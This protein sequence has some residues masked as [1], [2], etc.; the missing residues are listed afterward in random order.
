MLSSTTKMVL[1][2]CVCVYSCKCAGSH[3][4]VPPVTG[5]NHFLYLRD[6][7]MYFEGNHPPASQASNLRMSLLILSS[8]FSI[9][10]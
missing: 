3:V 10:L 9:L 1:W 4:P 8:L 7:R 5:E 6:Y 2:T